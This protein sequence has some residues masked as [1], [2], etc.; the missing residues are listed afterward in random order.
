[1]EHKPERLEEILESLCPCKL[2]PLTEGK[3]CIVDAGWYDRLIQ[4][5]WD[6][7]K[8]GSSYYAKRTI[9]RKSSEFCI[10]MHRVIAGT[11]TPCICHHRNGNSLDNRRC[12]LANMLKQTH[13]LLH[14]NN[15]ITIKYVSEFLITDPAYDFSL[16]S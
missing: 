4:Y 11:K 7:V 2:I 12:N 10:S 9:H 13:S 16:D 8:I 14:R 5:E 1:M 15:P 6:A 3:C